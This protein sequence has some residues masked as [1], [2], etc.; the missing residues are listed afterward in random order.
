MRVWGRR[1]TEDGREEI[2]EDKEMI[3]LLPGEFP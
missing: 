1:K 3:E 2:D